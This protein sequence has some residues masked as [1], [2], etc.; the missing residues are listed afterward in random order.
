MSIDKVS[1]FSSGGAEGRFTMCFVNKDLVLRGT[2]SI[3]Q[4]EG[5]DDC[6]LTAS[7]LLLLKQVL[8]I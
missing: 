4:I 3:T 1:S 8:R 6:S 2:L 7:L 5:V